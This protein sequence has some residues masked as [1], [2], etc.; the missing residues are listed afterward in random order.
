MELFDARVQLLDAIS[1]H[2]DIQAKLRMARMK[3]EEREDL[4]ARAAARAAA[5][6]RLANRPATTP[7]RSSNPFQ[8]EREK[9][10]AQSRAK[11]TRRAS[12]VATMASATREGSQGVRYS[13]D[14]D[15]RV[16]FGREASGRRTVT[17]RGKAWLQRGT[18]AADQAAALARAEAETVEERIA[19]L[20]LSL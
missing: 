2:E 4:E 9:L 17:D 12:Q 13:N 20:G 16:V 14:G 3:A 5:E 18:A 10:S 19:R 1:V 15:H 7:Q 11:F 8:Q 6:A